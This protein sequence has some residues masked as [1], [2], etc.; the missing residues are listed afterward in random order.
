MMD[1]KFPEGFLWGGAT[2]ANQIEGAYDVDGKGLSTADLLLG[3][4]FE[5]PRVITREVEEGKFYPSHEAI[6]SFH[7][8]KEDIKLF[9]EMGFKVYRFSIAWTRIFPTGLEDEPNEAGLAFYDRVIAE[10]KK[11]DIEP[12]VTISH[13]ESPI[14]MTRKFNGWESREAIAHYVKYAKVLL[15]RY[16]DDVKY[17][18]TF[19]EINI[20]TREMGTYLAGGMYA[21]NA[22]TLNQTDV[23]TE[24]M[25]YQALHNQFLASAE[26]VK[27]A[28]EFDSSLK[29]GCMLAYRMLYPL[30]S[31][32][33]DVALVQSRS[34]MNNF[35]C[36]DV[37]VTGRYPYFAKK[38]WRDHHITLNIEPEDADILA[39]GKVDFYSFSYYQ[40]SAVTTTDQGEVSQGNFFNGVKNPY[41][42]RSKWGWE[43]DPTGLRT[44][45]NQI[46]DRYQVPLMVVEN[47][48]G[49]RDE[50]IE[51]DGQ[52]TVKDDYR[53][54]YLRDHIAAMAGAIDDGV[55]LVGYT[56]WAPIDLVSASTGEMAKRYGYIY[57]DKYDD[58]TGTLERIRK[59][60][61][62]WYKKVIATNGA[63]LD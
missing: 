45:L 36:S 7:H 8:F 31:N 29:M 23:D 59:Q 37:Q 5:T 53:I 54:D 60:S 18:L 6:D 47:G 62:Y 55:D 57:V 12:L 34:Q 32:P 17:W 14:G 50:L 4:N 11:Y 51:V 46:Y 16:H 49:A 15:E 38:F 19:N 63:D 44:A 10:L 56:S 26:T 33:D 61:F 40:S 13:Y 39:A 48:L 22:N 41:V 3:G 35:Y 24:A 25:R 42:G 2:A 20:L 9:A 21:G 27:F 58:G 43:I 52:K 28:H 30:T 1:T